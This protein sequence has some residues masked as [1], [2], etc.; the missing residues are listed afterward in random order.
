MT[1]QEALTQHK[2]QRPECPRPFDPNSQEGITF[3]NELQA[4]CNEL[5]KLESAVRRE[6]FSIP[7]LD[8][9]PKCTPK[10][11]DYYFREPVRRKRR[12][13]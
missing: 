11:E 3:R 5:E 8:P 2:A 10:A 6:S 12:V 4:W 13:A 7:T 1:P 9:H